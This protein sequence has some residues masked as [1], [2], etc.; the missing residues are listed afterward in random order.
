M[1][2]QRRGGIGERLRRMVLGHR[3]QLI[4]RLERDVQDLQRTVRDPATVR[5]LVA[6]ALQEELKAAPAEVAAALLPT[7]ETHFA[8][9]AAPSGLRHARAS[10]SWL[11]AIVVAMLASLAVN[12]WRPQG[13]GV[14]E[15][16]EARPEH[17][18]PTAPQAVLLEQRSDGFGL[19]QSTLPDDQLAREVRARLA[20]CPELVGAPISFSVKD[21]WVW[22]RGETSTAGREAVTHA[23]ADLG[24]QAFVV[25]QL[26]TTDAALA[27]R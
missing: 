15:A 17:Q 23:L 16:T 27:Q 8:R 21:G 6:E 20:G 13:T 2:S 10:L 3:A 26:T 22:L 12:T 14:S 5:A 19:G 11:S 1:E 25:N 4:D 7:L 9:R 18:A 24:D